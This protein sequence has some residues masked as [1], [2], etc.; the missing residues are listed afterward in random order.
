MR[1]L[2]YLLAFALVSLGFGT[3]TVV[4]RPSNPPVPQSTPVIDGSATASSPVATQIT[5][6]LNHSALANFFLVYTWNNAIA[7]MGSTTVSMTNNTTT[8]SFTK[9]GCFGSS[10]GM[11]E[12]WYYKGTLNTSIRYIVD[13]WSLSNSMSFKASAWRGANLSSNPAALVQGSYIPSFA[14]SNAPMSTNGYPN[15]SLQVAI[16]EIAIWNC[17]TP[18]HPSASNGT[19]GTPQNIIGIGSCGDPGLNICHGLA[20]ISNGTGMGFSV[21]GTPYAG[22]VLY[23]ILN[24]TFGIPPPP[25]PPPPPPTILSSAI[26]WFWVL[27]FGAVCIGIVLAAWVFRKRYL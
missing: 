9:L 11:Y 2:A 8:A 1:L 23:I 25:P 4:A 17:G 22:V 18:Y 19:G 10:V 7:C 15:L 3:L 6:V 12:A 5:G 20:S 13:Q 16:V 27:L 14:C 26:T 21:S 24:G